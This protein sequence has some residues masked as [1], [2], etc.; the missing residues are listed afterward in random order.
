MGV[1]TV[2]Q[3]CGDFS[4]LF[5]SHTSTMFCLRRK[6]RVP[7][8]F[9]HRNFGMFFGWWRF[10]AIYYDMDAGRNSC[11]PASCG[12][13]DCGLSHRSLDYPRTEQPFTHSSF[14]RAIIIYT[15]MN[16]YIYI[17]WWNS[18]NKENNPDAVSV[19]YVSN[20]WSREAKVKKSRLV[21][22]RRRGALF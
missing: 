10:D 5:C 1:W 12:F 16:I 20:P 11:W 17:Y 7:F 19:Y 3:G 21:R 9:L 13:G 14:I 22:V 4:C 6:L 15:D 8:F 2:I 18:L